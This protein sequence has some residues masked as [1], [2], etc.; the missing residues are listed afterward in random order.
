MTPAKLLTCITLT[1]LLSLASAPSHAMDPGSHAMA[2]GA[3][4]LKLT[5]NPMGAFLIGLASHAL[6]DVVPHTNPP[7]K[8]PGTQAYLVA[9]GALLYDAWRRNDH[10][11]RIFW[12]AL[13]GVLPDAEYLHKG[14]KVFPTHN[15]TLKHGRHLNKTAAT[16]LMVVVNG[17]S[18]RA[19]W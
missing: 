10:D 13:G 2:G 7:L 18:Y 8:S 19:M 16:I 6:L 3:L 12:G 14:Q 1:A 5:K 15:G 11:P 17:I 4:G 9:D